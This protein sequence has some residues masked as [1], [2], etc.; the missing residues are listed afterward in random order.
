MQ[1]T[2]SMQSTPELAR[3]VRRHRRALAALC[4]ALSVLALGA[5][6]RPSTPATQP[7][8]V[9]AADLPSGHGLTPADLDVAHVAA[10]LAPPGVHSD[11]AA[12]PHRVLAAP[13]ARGEP[14]TSLRLVDAGGWSTA[15]GTTAVPVRVADPG[16]AALLAAGQRVDLMAAQGT[17]A[18]AAVGFGPAASARMI[19]E[20]VL[21]LAVVTPEGGT[22]ILG[23]VGD[24]EGTPL[25]VVQATRSEALAIVGARATGGVW[26]T[27]D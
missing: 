4:A 17:G 10:S 20:G 16:A 27:L 2:R 26:F 24:G 12:L 11:P 14:I 3:F 15:P 22:G 23:G 7:V 9:A 21:V 25:V 19:A 13:V 6:L 5:A 18:D 1:S 8:V